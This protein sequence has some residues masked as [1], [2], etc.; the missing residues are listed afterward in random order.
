MV[1]L[2]AV[3]DLTCTWPVRQIK[4]NFPIEKHNFF[5]FYV[6]DLRFFTRVFILQKCLDPNP[7]R[8]PNPNFFSDLDPAKTFGFFRIGIH[9]TDL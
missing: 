2:I 7:Y 1:A 8:Y 5:L 3:P 9:K 6:I 4:K